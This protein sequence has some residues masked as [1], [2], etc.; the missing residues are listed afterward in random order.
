MGSLTSSLFTPA[1]SPC[2]V[3]LVA[4]HTRWMLWSLPNHSR[5]WLLCDGRT[6]LDQRRPRS[7][8]RRL[9]L[10][11]HATLASLHGLLKDGQ[12]LFIEVHPPEVHL[13]QCRGGDHRRSERFD[14][15]TGA[16]VKGAWDCAHGREPSQSNPHET[17]TRVC[18]FVNSP[19][20]QDRRLPDHASE[21]SANQYD[22]R[23]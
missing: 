8:T 6:S 10:P 1:R 4:V 14:A 13:T 16:C 7:S 9:F 3:A 22:Q 11:H 20:N 19:L 5:L 17:D 12:G 21:Q 2:A 23:I 15:K 18:G